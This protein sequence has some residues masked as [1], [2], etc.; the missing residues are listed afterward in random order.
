MILIIL[1]HFYHSIL[2]HSFSICVGL[3]VQALNMV[4]GVVLGEDRNDGPDLHPPLRL[5]GSPEEED[6]IVR[7]FTNSQDGDLNW[8]SV[9]SL[10]CATGWNL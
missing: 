8:K 9:S 1:A 4:N 2:A 6:D 5:R 10:I 3:W 7:L